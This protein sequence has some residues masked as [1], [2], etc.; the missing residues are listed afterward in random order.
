[1]KLQQLK[2]ELAKEIGYQ[3]LDN[4]IDELINVGSVYTKERIVNYINELSIRV[5]QEQQKVIAGN[6]KV[7][8]LIA[9]SKYEVQ[10]DKS[11]IINEDNIIK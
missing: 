11:S 4:Y 10:V 1:M 6:V 8:N 5:Q 7:D 9:E 2:D 3:S